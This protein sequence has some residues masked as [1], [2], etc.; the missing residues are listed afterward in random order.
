MR[1][2]SL[3]RL[4]GI[5]DFSADLVILRGAGAPDGLPLHG[6]RLGRA[7]ALAYGV[8]RPPSAEEIAVLAERRRP[9]R[10]WVCLFAPGL[11]GGEDP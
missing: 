3:K 2:V 1:H 7:I 4:P 5:G 9:Y 8:D 10:T 6:P 11:A